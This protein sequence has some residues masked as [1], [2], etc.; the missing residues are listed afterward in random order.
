MFLYSSHQEGRYM[1]ANKK[2]ENLIQISG[3]VNPQVTIPAS[4][5]WIFEDKAVLD[6]VD[7]GMTESSNGQLIDRGS[8]AKYANGRLG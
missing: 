7:K 8:F 5:A 4:E 2:D 6:S 3:S 1:S